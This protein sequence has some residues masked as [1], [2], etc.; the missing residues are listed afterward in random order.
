[1]K[2][3]QQCHWIQPKLSN[4]GHEVEYIWED[5]T[6]FEDKVRR[7]AICKNAACGITGKQEM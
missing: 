7:P 2:D 6:A 4:L 5:R 3:G 1:M